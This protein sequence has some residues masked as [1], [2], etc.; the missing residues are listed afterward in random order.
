MAQKPCDWHLS[1]CPR[2][3]GGGEQRKAAV[4]GRAAA[5]LPFHMPLIKSVVN[6]SQSLRIKDAQ[7]YQLGFSKVSE[8]EIKL[9]LVRVM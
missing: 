1:P 3:A 4:V 9:F 5:R 7:T 8:Q 2:A 6:S